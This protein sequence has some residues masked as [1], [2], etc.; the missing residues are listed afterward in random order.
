M[1]RTNKC[2][3]SIWDNDDDSGDYVMYNETDI[4]N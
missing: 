3:L 2:M 1:C 4:I